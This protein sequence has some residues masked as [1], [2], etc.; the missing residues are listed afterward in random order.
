MSERLEL[1]PD[2]RRAAADQ[3]KSRNRQMLRAA[4]LGVAVAA[5]AG[6]SWWAG[7]SGKSGARDAGAVPEIHPDAAPVK[8]APANPGGMVV[9]D[10]DSVLLNHDAKPKIEELLP[11]PEAVKTRPAAPSPPA[12]SQ[13]AVAPA[14]SIASPS[15]VAAAP[16][17]PQPPKPPQIAAVPTS[18]PAPAAPR[19]PPKSP[20]TQTRA[21]GS[22]YRLQLGALKSEDAAKQE[23]L[24]LQR[25]QP[26]VLGKLALT[27]S[28]V[29]LGAKGTYYRIQAGPIADFSQAAQSCAALKSR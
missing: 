4:L 23:W 6:G 12:P 18:L 27:V 3:P 16:P 9:P 11:P 21:T 22:G 14:A 17:P 1:R 8:E 20:L 2:E 13:T 19:A 15:P 10:Q 24:R 25:Q 5:L 28:R 26:D 7:H 29:D